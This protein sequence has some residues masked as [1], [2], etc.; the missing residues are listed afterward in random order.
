MNSLCFTEVGSG[1]VSCCGRCSG[2]QLV[3]R[4]GF[5]LHEACWRRVAGVS[6][7]LVVQFPPIGGQDRSDRPKRRSCSAIPPL[8]GV[9]ASA[10][11]VVVAKVQTHWVKG[12]QKRRFW[13]NGSALW[14]IH[15]L[16]LLVAPTDFRPPRGLFC[17]AG[18][19]RGLF[20]WAGPLYVPVGGGPPARSPHASPAARSGRS[21]SPARPRRRPPAPRPGPAG[22]AA[23][24]YRS[25]RVV[26][27]LP[28]LVLCGIRG[29]CAEHEEARDCCRQDERADAHVHKGAGCLS[30]EESL[31]Q[32]GE[33][34]EAEEAPHAS[35][36]ACHQ[37][38]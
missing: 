15:C 37:L 1:R 26:C 16:A 17:W 2:L 28:G 27:V 33:Q 24:S 31:E 8:G 35:C 12:T 14:R 30:D 29:A 11:S 6:E 36:C 3:G 23:A 10:W 18:P 4:G 9:G 5:A 34:E 32:P 19:P 13:L 22:P 20:C 7:P 38:L 21:R 25:G